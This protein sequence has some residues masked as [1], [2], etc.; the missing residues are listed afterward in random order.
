MS[1]GFNYSKWDKI[2]LSDDEDD[3]HPNIDK[4]SWF[5]MKHRSRVERE[6]N[7]AKEVKLIDIGMKKAK[8]RI[9]VLEHDLEKL[10]KL[11][12]EEYDDDDDDDDDLDDKEG[13]QA[14][15]D[16][17]RTSN[18]A[19]T[20][21]LEEI[22]KNKTWNVDNMCEVK[23][24]R[25]IINANAVKDNYT[26]TGFAK[27]KD[28]VVNE[29]PAVTPAPP[30]T[31]RAPTKVAA[32]KPA[33][34]QDV[35]ETTKKPA[36]AAAVAPVVASAGPARILEPPHAMDTYHDFT[37]KYSEVVEEFMHMKSLEASKE[38]LLKYGDVLLQENA[39]NYL[40]LASLE[41]EMNGLHDKMK[42]TCRQS[43][44]I[45]NIAELAKSM[46]THPGN[47]VIPFFTRLQQKPLFDGFMDGVEAFVQKIV[48]RAVTKK[49]E[50]DRERIEEEQANAHE[51]GTDLEDIPK[52]QR[53]G[54][55]G[56]DP[57]E[58]IETLPIEMQEAFE[59]RDIDT[60]KEVLLNMDPEDAA[61]HMKNC[62]DSGL[63]C[64]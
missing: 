38:Y 44:I 5:R 49:E 28:E 40:L 7:E 15:L 56:L 59:S 6:E 30:A 52:E 58:V 60:L 57:L 32:A 22:E 35:V 39:S 14:E 27:S 50:M 55:G 21:R 16:E 3:L 64:D 8:Q 18:A 63:W 2:E 51:K 48:N 53:L 1:K 41:D 54:P 20:K 26:P 62:V 36:A 33:A 13:L 4:E 37:V 23:E 10:D 61:R 29:E 34:K 31:D 45:S 19:R 46:H 9:K 47:V 12:V 25:T 11:K 42:L 24:E 17:L 43:Q